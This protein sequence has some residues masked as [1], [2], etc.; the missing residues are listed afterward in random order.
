MLPANATV[1]APHNFFGS[2]KLFGI[3]VR[4][5][6]EPSTNWL[7]VFD[8]APTSAAVATASRIESLNASGTLLVPPTGDNT[9]VLFG[10]GT[11]G[12]AITGPIAYAQ[13]ATATKLFITDLPPGAS[14]TIGVTV[15][16][17]THTVTLTPASSGMTAS[18]QGTL[19][20]AIDADGRVR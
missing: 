10:R 1:S 12:T 16:G 13:P 4:G 11:A 7:T 15:V 8:T 3:Q 2:N 6:V 20:V 9:V 17:A 19:V 18:S 5:A 14:Y